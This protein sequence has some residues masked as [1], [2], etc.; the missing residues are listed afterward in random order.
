MNQTL[1]SA[2]RL[3]KIISF[4]YNGGTRNVE[5][6][7]YG[8]STA[9]NE[10]LRAYQIGG[11]SQSGKSVGWKLFRVSNISNLKVIDKSFENIRPEYNPRDSAMTTIYCN[12]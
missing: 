3:R 6:Y 9:G 12:V 8:I 10:L 7:C 2:I 5:P 1:F 4:Y 11:Y